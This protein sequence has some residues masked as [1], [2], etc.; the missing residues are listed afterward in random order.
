M[1]V[2]QEVGRIVGGSYAWSRAHFGA[3]CVVSAPL[4][5]GLDL[6]DTPTLAS[7]LP[8][9]TNEEAIAVNQNWAGHPGRL[10]A[11][12]YPPGW[13]HAPGAYSKGHDRPGWPRNA[14]LADAE[15]ACEGDKGCS[16]LT[17]HSPEAEPTAPVQIYLK[18]VGATAN[19]DHNW[20]HYSRGEP[21]QVGAH[22]TMG[23]ARSSA[24]LRSSALPS[25]RTP[26]GRRI[27]CAPGVGEAAAGRQ[28]RRVRGKPGRGGQGRDGL[29][30]L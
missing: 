23:T 13:T 12:F 1:R 8:F 29:C 15:R 25:L 21:V 4:I 3:W 19:A 10:A 11:E 22:P 6:S 26:R 5:L 14:T 30:R 2:R 9:V 16:G 28:A 27:R 18:D 20:T 7:I 24:H 17:Y